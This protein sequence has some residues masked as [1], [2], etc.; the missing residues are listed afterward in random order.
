MKMTVQNI[1]I[2]LILIENSLLGSL[3]GLSKASVMEERRIEKIITYSNA[4][5][6]MTYLRPARKGYLNS[7]KFRLGLCYNLRSLIRRISK[8]SS[9]S[10]SK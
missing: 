8:Y 10:M 4:Y 9:S 1:S 2:L 3:R 5:V 6:S 7:K